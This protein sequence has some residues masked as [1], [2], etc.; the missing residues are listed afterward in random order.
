MVHWA[1]YNGRSTVGSDDDDLGLEVANNADYRGPRQAMMN[2]KKQTRSN[3]EIEQEYARLDREKVE[4]SVG[5]LEA[6]FAAWLAQ[7]RVKQ[8]IF[9]ELKSKAAATDDP[10]H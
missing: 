1:T 10:K 6:T 5:C 9:L 3:E 2:R 7:E 8:N 4:A